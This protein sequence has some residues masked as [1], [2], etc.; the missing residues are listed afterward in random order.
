MGIGYRKTFH[1]KFMLKIM[2]KCSFNLTLKVVCKTEFDESPKKIQV[3]HHFLQYD[4]KVVSFI[5]E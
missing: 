5:S 2:I 4:I 1:G 3:Y